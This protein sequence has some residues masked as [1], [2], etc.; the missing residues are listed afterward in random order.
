MILPHPPYQGHRPYPVFSGPLV[1]CS[2]QGPRRCLL[3][4][5]T[6]AASGGGLGQAGRAGNQRAISGVTGPWRKNQI[7]GQE[8]EPRPEVRRKQARLP[9]AGRRGRWM[10]RLWELGEEGGVQPRGPGHASSNTE[11]LQE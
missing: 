11:G 10:E 4:G 2:E 6:E 7:R 1:A 8:A 5:L 9:S 3:R